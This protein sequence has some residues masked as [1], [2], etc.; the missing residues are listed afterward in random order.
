MQPSDLHDATWGILS[1]VYGG[2][3]HPTAEGYAA[4]ADAALATA[5]AVLRLVPAS[6]GVTV[7]PLAPP[8]AADHAKVMRFAPVK[9]HP[10]K[11]VSARSSADRRTPHE[12]GSANHSAC[13]RPR[14]K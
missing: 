13:V 9:A 11:G 2:A 6:E 14:G 8:V 7:T 5:R 1:A 10:A 12:P 4:M 3:I